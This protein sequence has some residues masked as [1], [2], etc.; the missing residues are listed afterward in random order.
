MRNVRL[1]RCFQLF[2]IFCAIIEIDKHIPTFSCASLGLS[3]IPKCFV[4]NLILSLHTREAFIHLGKKY[5]DVR[6]EKKLRMC[7]FYILTENRVV[8]TLVSYY[9]LVKASLIWVSCVSL[10]YLHIAWTHYSLH[11]GWSVIQRVS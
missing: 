2:N 9:F 3:A 5:V 11:G 4:F 10:K 7:C 8:C 1:K 6:K